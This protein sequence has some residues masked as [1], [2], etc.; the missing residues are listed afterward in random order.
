M[1][2]AKSSTADKVAE[3]ISMIF[4]PL[5]IGLPTLIIAMV[6]RGSSF[7]GAVLWTILAT[8]IVNLP[9]A[10]LIGWGVRTGKYSDA[11]VSIRQQRTSVYLV[12]IACMVLLSI[13]LYFGKAPQ[14]MIACLVAAV[15]SIIL[16]FGINRYTK[17]SLHSAAIAG[18]ATVLLLTVPPIGIFATVCAPL[19]AWARIHLKHH[20]PFQIL[21]GWMVPM[22]SVIVIFQLLL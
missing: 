22:L 10:L 1:T 14:I 3:A 7:W 9:V 4:H 19:V 13:I 20:T 16:G 21:I 12:G 17:I 6:S 5:L 15:V 2:I 18:C 11:S 8:G